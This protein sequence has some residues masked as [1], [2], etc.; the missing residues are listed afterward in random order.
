MVIVHAI[1]KSQTRLSNSAQH[2]A[3]ITNEL[4][5][6]SLRFTWGSFFNWNF[7]PVFFYHVFLS[8]ISFPVI[9][10]LVDNESTCRKVC[11]YKALCHVLCGTF[12]KL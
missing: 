9:F 8:N 12:T 6:H 5:V 10:N 7:L 4:Y 1:A 2:S 3:S 11:L